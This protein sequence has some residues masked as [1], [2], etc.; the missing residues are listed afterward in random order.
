M[1]NGVIDKG[2]FQAL[3][4]GLI[5]ISKEFALYNLSK[6]YLES[7][8]AGRLYWDGA[9]STEANTEY[10]VTREHYDTMRRAYLECDIITYTEA[11]EATE[12][13]YKLERIEPTATE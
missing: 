1:H 4:L 2:L 7:L 11:S 9:S 8:V 6:A 10:Y 12:G 5:M 3:Q 13:K